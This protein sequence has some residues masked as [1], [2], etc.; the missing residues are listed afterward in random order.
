MH[1]R[2][3]A[4]TNAAYSKQIC[5]FEAHDKFQ[6][7]STENGTYYRVDLFCSVYFP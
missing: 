2:D 5:S 6:Y 7:P 4:Y 1:N 3:R